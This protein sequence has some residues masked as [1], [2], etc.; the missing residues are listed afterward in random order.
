MPDPV[1]LVAEPCPGCAVGLLSLARVHAADLD[2]PAMDADH[3]EDRAFIF[4]GTDVFD[5]RGRSAIVGRRRRSRSAIAGNLIRELL[6]G[7]RI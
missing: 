1:R 6:F 4:I 3:P 2:I 5:L 7:G